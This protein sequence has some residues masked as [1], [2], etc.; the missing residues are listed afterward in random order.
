MCW[1]TRH[2]PTL[3]LEG[4]RHWLLAL[5]DGRARV[6]ADRIVIHSPRSGRDPPA[7]LE[8]LRAEGGWQLPADAGCRVG[9]ELTGGTS[10]QI[11]ITGR[12]RGALVFRFA[13]SPGLRPQPVRVQWPPR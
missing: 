6:T 3:A 2:S 13:D 12:K 9:T 11:Q 5:R 8:S 4:I 10:C 7:R 1:P